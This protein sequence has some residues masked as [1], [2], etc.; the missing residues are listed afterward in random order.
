MNT[1]LEPTSAD[2][3]NRTVFDLRA[4]WE[5]LTDKVEE[6]LTFL[7]ALI[8]ELL[9]AAE[10]LMCEDEDCTDVLG[11]A[12]D[13]E[14]Y[15]RVKTTY[16]SSSPHLDGDSGEDVLELGKQVGGTVESLQLDGGL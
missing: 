4:E 11:Y 5:N 9:N 14:V 8:I 16:T 7:E 13:A 1:N 10:P 12:I 15:E 2:E 3:I 6:R